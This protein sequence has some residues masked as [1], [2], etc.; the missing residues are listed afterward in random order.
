MRFISLF[1]IVAA[2]IAVT[3]SPMP[4][5]DAPPAVDDTSSSDVVSLNV[6]AKSLLGI[7]LSLGNFY[8]APNPPWTAGSHPGWY[9]GDHGY[10]FPE[11]T[12]LEGVRYSTSIPYS[13]N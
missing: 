1:T 8:G 9:F 11:L 4:A 5:D 2:A 6:D 3:A 12:C 10:L 7:D 13:N